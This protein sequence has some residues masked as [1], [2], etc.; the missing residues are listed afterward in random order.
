[1]TEKD[2]H[3]VNEWQVKKTRMQDRHDM[4]GICLD[5]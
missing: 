1:M 5:E 4:Y 3:F 2:S